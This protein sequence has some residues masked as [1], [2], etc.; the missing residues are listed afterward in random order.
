MARTAI[1]RS[2]LGVILFLSAAQL[3]YHLWPDSAFIHGI[4]IDY[5]S[6]TLYL[7]DVFIVVYLSISKEQYK[8]NRNPWLLAAIPVLLVNILYSHNSL[9][10]LAWW[11]RFLLYGMFSLSVTAQEIRKVLPVIVGTM[12]FQVTLGVAQIVSGS[13]LQGLMYWLGE[14]ALDVSSPN[15]A[16][17][18]WLGEVVLRA[19]GTFSH[20]NTL[21]GWL[22]VCTVISTYLLGL[23]T[24]RKLR[25]IDWTLFGLIVVSAVVG[26][27]IADSRT[28][29]LSLFGV[30]FPVMLW[31]WKR[32]RLVYLLLVVVMGSGL[33]YTG[34]IS[35]DLD[36]SVN[37]RFDLQKI[38]IRILE[39]WPV[40]GTGANASLSTYP[41]IDRNFRLYQPDH[42]SFMLFL[43]WF[44]LAGV[45]AV[46]VSFQRPTFDV[47]T[48]LPLFPLLVLDHYLFTSHQGLLIMMLYVRIVADI[49]SNNAENNP[50]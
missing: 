45:L 11:A 10:S 2:I 6:P 37:Q 40:F 14:R 49:Q 48:L 4:R 27:V 16:K 47:I 29:A 22:V 7:T 15:V 3:G 44:G 5:L 36:L 50:G 25:R 46:L 21:A 43:S 34:R 17:S 24:S 19:Y 13:A 33:L 8:K 12:M 31:K 1:R 30:V 32:L 38:S 9:A 42:N 23:H 28:A 39:N 41:A 26:V 20:P 18:A 35:R